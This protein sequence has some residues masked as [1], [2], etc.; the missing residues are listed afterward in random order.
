LFQKN[1]AKITQRLKVYKKIFNVKWKQIWSTYQTKHSRNLCLTLTNDITI[2]RLKLHEKLTKLESN[3]ATQ[4][5]TNQIKLIDYLFSKR[6]SNVVSSTCFCDW[7]KQNV[8]HI[9]LQC[10]DHS[11]KRNNMLRENDTTNFKRLKII[12]KKVKTIINWFMKTSLLE[13][14]SLTTKLIE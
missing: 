5:R 7:I 10:F 9:V 4:I 6:V 12:V 1:K 8:K 3:L 13:Q 14:F 11:Q 2:K